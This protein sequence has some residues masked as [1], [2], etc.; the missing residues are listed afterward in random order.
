MKKVI[1][2]LMV[3][4]VAGD[5]VALQDLPYG[6]KAAD[7]ITTT[8]DWCNAR[9][10][11][12][13]RDVIQLA[14]AVTER[15]YA[16]QTGT[17]SNGTPIYAIV[18]PVTNLIGW[19][20]AHT[21]L[22]SLD[23]KIKS[24]PP[25]FLNSNSVYE[26]A[27][28]NFY[29]M[30]TTGLWA[31]L[32]VGDG[33]NK[34]TRSPCW[35]NPVAT[36]WIVNYTS[37]WPRTNGTTTNINYTSSYQQVISYATNWALVVS[38]STVDGVTKVA[39][40]SVWYWATVS[41]WPNVVAQTTNAATYGDYGNYIYKVSLEERYKVLQAMRYQLM[42]DYYGGG[43]QIVGCSGSAVF[44]GT[45][46]LSPSYVWTMYAFPNKLSDADGSYHT[47]NVD[48]RSGPRSVCSSWG[49]GA[50]HM[51]QL[52]QWASAG[53]GLLINCEEGYNGNDGT[54]SATFAL[55]DNNIV[56]RILNAYIVPDL[57]PEFNTNPQLNYTASS[58]S[59]SV[60]LAPT[61][62]SPTFQ[63]RFNVLMTFPFL[64]CTNKYW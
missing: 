51:I 59:M 6:W 13:A 42:G 35:T 49:M 19:F 18:P 25:Y 38:T 28:N 12:E 48:S 7:G 64:Y 43:T 52:G 5:V 29:Y 11:V 40:N 10:Q 16:T 46:P 50:I 1:Y 30:T 54:Y 17:N 36:N 4:W 20:N 45:A 41:N 32:K 22:S 53:N 14:L 62:Y 39:T 60:G 33:T 63:V 31:S 44:Q 24:L 61:M 3:C 26:G 57:H 8:G 58:L 27:T 56:A 34:F 15:C 21:I 9:E 23:T 47:V 2:I 55:V 37:Y